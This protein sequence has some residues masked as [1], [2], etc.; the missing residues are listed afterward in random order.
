MDSAGGLGSLPL[1]LLRYFAA[2]ESDVLAAEF[3]Q[4]Y[5]Q[6][7]SESRLLAAGMVLKRSG[8]GARAFLDAAAGV[9]ER[10]LVTPVLYAAAALAPHASLGEVK[11]R[12]EIES[13]LPPGKTVREPY[14]PEALVR[15]AQRQAGA[16]F[17][18]DARK[19]AALALMLDASNET[20][21]RMLK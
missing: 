18:A 16:G 4:Q 19:Q 5:D 15:L 21:W 20:A 12:V 2:R 9:T 10:D 1:R 17:A 11:G 8:E 13:W 6:S 3:L 7:L 14:N